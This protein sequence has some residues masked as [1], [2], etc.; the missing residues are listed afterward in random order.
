MSQNPVRRPEDWPEEMA[1]Q[2][3]GCGLP[4]RFSFGFSQC[5]AVATH[6]S[7]SHLSCG[8]GRR[9][10]I[11]GRWRG[12]RA[13]GMVACAK[14][15]EPQA[16][17]VRC[18]RPVQAA[19]LDVTLFFLAGRPW[20]A[21][22]EFS[23]SYTT[24]PAPSLQGNWQPLEISRFSSDV[25]TLRRAEDGRL[26]MDFFGIFPTGNDA[27]DVFRLTAKLPGGRATGFRLDAFPVFIRAQTSRF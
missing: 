16:L 24:D 11:C 13:A 10:V 27:D 4:A 7:G 19:E 25:H 22:A 17:V 3:F 1:A 20:N 21:M 6:S 26:H 15:S 14:V 18:E 23:L 8:S 12:C 9:V 5:G 2:R